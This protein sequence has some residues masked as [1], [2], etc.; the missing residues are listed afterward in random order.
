MLFNGLY[1]QRRV[2]RERD[3]RT[4]AEKAK[5]EYREFRSLWYEIDEDKMYNEARGLRDAGF[6]CQYWVY[7]VLARGK[8]T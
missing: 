2:P 1:T 6:D 8:S 4:N 7:T 3:G 5:P